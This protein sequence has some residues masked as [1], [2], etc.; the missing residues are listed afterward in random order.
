MP[1]RSFLPPTR[2]SATL[3]GTCWFLCGGLAL[4]TSRH[5]ID[6]Q[7]ARPEMDLNEQRL[8]DLERALTAAEEAEEQRRVWAAVE[9]RKAEK[10]KA[11]RKKAKPAPPPPPPP[12]IRKN[13][14]WIFVPKSKVRPADGDASA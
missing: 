6:A 7:Y 1:G 9:R 5:C 8:A 13:G 12:A 11:E 3:H 10:A 4:A 2:A 14:G